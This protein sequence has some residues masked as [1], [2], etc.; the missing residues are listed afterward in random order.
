MYNIILVNYFM[1]Q[2]NV[3][4]VNYTNILKINKQLK[5]LKVKK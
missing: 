5:K 3:K 1:D 4:E 2:Q